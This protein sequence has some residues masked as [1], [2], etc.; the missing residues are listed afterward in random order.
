[1]IYQF[2]HP[3]GPKSLQVLLLKHI[4][5][6]LKVVSQAYA[7]AEA[8]WIEVQGGQEVSLGLLV[9]LRVAVV[10]EDAAAAHVGVQGEGAEPHGLCVGLQSLLQLAQSA[11]M[12][13]SKTHPTTH[14]RLCSHNAG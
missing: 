9:G 12:R 7:C 6:Y 8:E 3:L 13:T 4:M 5:L 11:Y 2:Y 10:H 14:I 1:M